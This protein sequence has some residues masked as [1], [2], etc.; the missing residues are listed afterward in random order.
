MPHSDLGV[1]SGV[2]PSFSQACIAFAALPDASASFHETP[3]F[4]SNLSSGTTS[5]SGVRIVAL[6]AMA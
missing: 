3:N 6:L 5:W 2:I 4:S 1:F